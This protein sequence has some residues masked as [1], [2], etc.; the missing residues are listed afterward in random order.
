MEELIRKIFFKYLSEQRVPKGY[1][2]P[3]T[4]RQEASKYTRL[5]DFSKFN[6][7]A[8]NQAKKLGKDFFEEIT[9]HMPRPR[10]LRPYTDQ[11]L[12]DIAKQYNTKKEFMTNSAWQVAYKRGHDFYNKI[13]S[14]MKTLGS[15]N[16]RMVYAYF[17]PE[18]NAVYVG[19]TY[20]IDERNF[21]HLYGEKHLT[22]VRKFI[23]LTKEVPKLVKLTNYIDVDEASL[24]EDELINKFRNQGYI[25]LNKVKGGGV[26]GGLKYSDEDLGKVASQYN[27]L[28]DF[29]EKERPVYKAIRSRGLLDKLTSHMVRG[30]ET[31]SEEKIRNLAKDF[32]SKKDFAEKYPGAVNHAKKIGIWDDLFPKKTFPS[33]E[34]IIQL[35]M[36]YDTQNDFRIAHPQIYNY[37]S[38]EGLLS[39][40]TFKKSKK[41]SA[42]LTDDDIIKR[43]KEYQTFK[44]FYTNDNTAYRAAKRRGDDFYKQVTSHMVQ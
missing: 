28:K 15:K 19:L 7:Y 10:S 43:A 25:I 5:S 35:G 4:L 44:E 40:I 17:F 29:I 12:I 9:A 37:A 2:N 34:E 22:S 8:F 30:I 16:K 18:N 11:E 3:E 31:W 21:Q 1:W 23:D 6:Q 26:G 41:K 36:N 39:K 38:N 24:K 27:I 13:T 33:H 20:D 14:H 32:L 42:T